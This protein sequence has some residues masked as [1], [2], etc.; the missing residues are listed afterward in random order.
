MVGS[1]IGRP[2][3]EDACGP[4]AFDCKGLVM[5]VQRALWGRQVPLRAGS[6]LAWRDACRGAGWAPTEAPPQPGDVLLVRAIDG[7]HVGVFVRAN[8]RLMVLHARS[9][10]RRGVQVGR[11]ELHALPDLLA[12]GYARPQVWRCA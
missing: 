12:I 9:Q 6:W 4:Q 7:A 8:R 5:A 10:L 2:Y 3:R 11:V 1:F